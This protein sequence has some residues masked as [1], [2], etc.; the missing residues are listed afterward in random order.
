MPVA[1]QI[2][3][4]PYKGKKISIYEVFKDGWKH[5]FPQVD[6]MAIDSK[7]TKDITEAIKEAVAQ[8]DGQAGAYMKKMSLA[9]KIMQ[10]T[11]E[12]EKKKLEQQQTMPAANAPVVGDES[13]D[14]M[15]DVPRKK[16][17]QEMQMKPADILNQD[18]ATEMGAADTIE[19]A[20]KR[21]VIEAIKEAA[22]PEGHVN[23]DVVNQ[24]GAINQ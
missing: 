19:A 8:I 6:G 3:V 10:G 5:Y 15:F 7:R 2:K 1:K 14:P 4:V 22:T 20:I 9:E 16:T 18:V 24:M 12:A 13:G 11:E 23:K 21:V 17:D